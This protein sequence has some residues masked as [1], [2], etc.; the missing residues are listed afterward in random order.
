MVSIGITLLAQN[1][2]LMMTLDNGDY[3]YLNS[4]L[5]WYTRFL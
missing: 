4:R 5:G 1:I 2:N 3:N